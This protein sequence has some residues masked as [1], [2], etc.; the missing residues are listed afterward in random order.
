MIVRF[1]NLEQ[2]RHSEDPEKPDAKNKVTE[3]MGKLHD[4]GFAR[5]QDI[6]KGVGNGRL[7]HVFDMPHVIE[8][9]ADVREAVEIMQPYSEYM[10]PLA[11]VGES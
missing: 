6:S 2:P 5:Q 8:F 11:V 1:G 7:Y 10:K 4:A 3:M 9:G